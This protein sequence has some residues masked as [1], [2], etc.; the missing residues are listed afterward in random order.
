MSPSLTNRKQTQTSEFQDFANHLE[1]SVAIPRIPR[2]L[3]NHR[4]RPKLSLR[5]P[6]AYPCTHFALQHFGATLL[7]KHSQAEQKKKKSEN[8]IKFAFL[9]S[10]R[11]RGKLC[12]SEG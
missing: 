2:K 5:I 3:E 4:S 1:I 10:T 11:G 7:A 9:R 6:R 8:A 12:M